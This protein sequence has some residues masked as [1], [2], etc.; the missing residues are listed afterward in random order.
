MHTE[1]TE[2]RPHVFVLYH[3]E[4]I[5]STSTDCH[6]A[7]VW[8]SAVIERRKLRRDKPE[9]QECEGGENMIRSLSEGMSHFCSV[10]CL[11]LEKHLSP[12]GEARPLGTQLQHIVKKKK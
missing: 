10:I 6:S 9:R 3:E 8:I 12:Q 11:N 7:A 5:K 2:Q 4:G 1:K